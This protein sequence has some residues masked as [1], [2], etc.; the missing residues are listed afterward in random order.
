MTTQEAYRIGEVAERVRR[1]IVTEAVE[2]VERQLVLVRSREQRLARFAQELDAKLRSLRKRRRQLEQA[3]V[4]PS[5]IADSGRMG[6]ACRP[7][8]T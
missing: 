1:R 4:V 7:T 3:R 8:G 6:S 2:H 5:P